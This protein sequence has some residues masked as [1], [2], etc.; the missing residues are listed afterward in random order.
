MKILALLGTIGLAGAACLSI[1]LAVSQLIAD[2]MRLA[3]SLKS[4]FRV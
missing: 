1:S 2:Y 3:V 4:P